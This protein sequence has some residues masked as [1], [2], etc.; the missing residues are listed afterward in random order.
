M[1][2]W[3]GEKNVGAGGKLLQNAP[4]RAW[5]AFVRVEGARSAT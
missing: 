3:E 1:R 5:G 4:G 2:L